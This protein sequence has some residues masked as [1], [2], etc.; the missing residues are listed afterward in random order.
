MRKNISPYADL[1]ELGFEELDPK[2]FTDIKNFLK[3]PPLPVILKPLGQQGTEKYL[4]LLSEAS[5]L[6]PSYLDIDYGAFFLVDAIK[7]KYPRLK[8]ILSY[9]DFDKFPTNLEQ[10]YL[11]MQCEGVNFYKIAVSTVDAIQSLKILNFSKGKKN[12]ITVGMGNHGKIT[13]ILSPVVNNPITYCHADSMPSLAS[14]QMAIS[15]LINVYKH[16]KLSDKTKIYCLIGNPTK[17]SISHITHNHFFQRKN[18][19]AVYVKIDIE[20]KQLSLF[21][22]EATRLPFRGISVTLPLKK[23]VA[24]FLSSSLPL[25]T[26]HYDNKKFSGISTD[27]LGAVKTLKQVIS[28]KRKTVGIIGGT[29]GCGSMIAEELTQKGSLVTVITRNEQLT[30]SVSGNI[31]FRSLYDK[32]PKPYDILINAAPVDFPLPKHLV[33]P[34]SVVM[35]VKTLP[36]VTLF[37]S[38]AHKIGCRVIHGRALFAHQAIEQFNFWGLSPSIFSKDFFSKVK[39]ITEKPAVIYE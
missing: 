10:L 33:S 27:G 39:E 21:F 9:H 15:E 7:K 29:G 13:R 19:D 26:L 24:S 5:T 1:I 22:E 16:P 36:V 3:N 20:P 23:E 30:N 34:K 6:E 37:L 31:Y 4:K 32:P 38:E 17:Q 25:N 2:T 35:D 18:I 14:G 8:I 12:L 11:D 28:L